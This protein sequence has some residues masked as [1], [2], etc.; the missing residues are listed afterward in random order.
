[1]MPGL[2]SEKRGTSAERRGK[3]SLKA[4]Q[5]RAGEI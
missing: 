2:R 5:R 1:V 3:A 4:T